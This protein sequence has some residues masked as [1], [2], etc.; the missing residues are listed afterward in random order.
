MNIVL[1]G[2]TKGLGRA[3]G[4]GLA[5][6]GHL[7]AGC[8]RSTAAIASLQDEL[9]TGHRLDPVDVADSVAVDRWAESVVAQ[10][11]PPDL[12]INNAA[13][14]NR[15]AP[16]WEVEVEELHRLLMVNVAGSFHVI[17]SFLP[18]M[19]KRGSG[20]IANMSSGWGRVTAPEVAPYCTSKWAI[21]GMT[22]ALSQELPEGLA[23]VAVNPGIIDT[24]MLRSCWGDQAGDFPSAEDWAARAVPFFL[25]LSPRDN[26]SSTT[27]A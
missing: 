16:L 1:T 27:V 21:E 8:G 18:A 13:I 20:V 22:R 12:V 25:G 10:L 14:M 24:D 2:I 6:E 3:L 17:R 4:K 23:A 9:G 11:G 19:L 5:R 26:G 7:L 15:T